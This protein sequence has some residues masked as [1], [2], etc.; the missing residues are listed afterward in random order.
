MQRRSPAG[1]DVVAIGRTRGLTR[2]DMTWN[3]AIAPIE[4]DPGDGRVSLDG[5]PL[6]VAAVDEVPLSRRYLLR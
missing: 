2:A 4:I 3:R 6:A 5:R 1:R